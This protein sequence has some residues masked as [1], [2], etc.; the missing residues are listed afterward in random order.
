[1]IAV[2]IFFIRDFFKKKKKKTSIALKQKIFINRFYSKNLKRL[3]CNDF[4]R[5]DLL[6]TNSMHL[7]TP[8][9]NIL[10]V[11]P[12]TKTDFPLSLQKKKQKN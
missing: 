8:N 10:S 7:F 9:F 1:M 6:D 4:T 5:H 11:L 3:T 2:H 12:A